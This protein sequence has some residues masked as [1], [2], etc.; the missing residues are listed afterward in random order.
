MA[1]PARAVERFVAPDAL[2]VVEVDGDSVRIRRVN[3]AT[4]DARGALATELLALIDSGT[5]GPLLRAMP[6]LGGDLRGLSGAG[7]HALSPTRALE[8]GGWDLLFIELVGRC[9]ERCIHCYADAAPEVESELSLETCVA[10]IDAAA[11]LGFARVQLTGGDPLL[12]PF[13]PELVERAARLG[14]PAEIYT[15]GL[16][17]SQK[18]LERLAPHKPTLAFS[19]Y[20]HDPAVH[21][22][23]TQTPNS[24]AL[25]TRAIERAVAAG[26]PV[27]VS[28]IVMEENAHDLAVTCAFLRARGV[29]QLAFAPTR[30]VGRGRNFTG[31]IDYSLV[32]R[33]VSAHGGASPSERGSRS[34]H[35]RGK[36]AVASNGDVYPCIFN[37]TTP[38]GNIAQRS[39]QQIVAAPELRRSLLGTDEADAE[40]LQCV[41]CRLTATALRACPRAIQ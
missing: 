15:N 17:L 21:D 9:N 12:C 5:E 4:I 29:E 10:L 22:A 20:S 2:A 31:A 38:L 35:E 3:G 30:S 18:L 19:F 6:E 14:V 28:I 13:V 36:L 33:G 11:A 37:R 32:G 1:V 23:I 40:R 16:L 34:S 25:T 27:R 8:L 26:F 24:Q 7:R 39:L 41:G